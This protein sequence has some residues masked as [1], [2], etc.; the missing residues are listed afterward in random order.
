MK[1]K[2]LMGMMAF[3]SAAVSLSAFANVTNDWFSADAS[4]GP[5]LVNVSTGGTFTVENSKFVIDNELST[6]LEFTPT[7]LLTATN[8]TNIARIDVTAFLTASKTNDFVQSVDGANAGFA[9]GI[10]DADKTNY[11]GYVKG[12]WM[13]LGGTPLPDGQETSFS[14]ILN[15]RD[16]AVRF[17]VGNVDIGGGDITGTTLNR[18]NAFGEGSISS[19]TSGYEVAVCAV[20]NGV[21]TNKYGSVAEAKSHAGTES[22]IK[23]VEPDGTVPAATDSACGLPI[24]VCKALGI[25]VADENANIAVAPAAADK[26]VNGITLSLANASDA[27]EAGIVK[28]GVKQDGSEEEPTYY[29]DATAITI[30]LKAGTY[31]I[32]PVLK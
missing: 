5:M 20:D 23:D 17:I 9:V 8:S 6:A 18:I 30:P 21:V 10:D 1:S 25:D 28:F 7:V 12:A 26:A 19:I 3:A 27:P 13:K 29:E 14:L 32:T 24:A 31:T 2:T 16:Q 22:N 4:K 11:Y 15:Y